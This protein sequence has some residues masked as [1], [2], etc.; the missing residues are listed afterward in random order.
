MNN[1][2]RLILALIAYLAIVYN[3][4]EIS[5]LIGV[6]STLFP[7]LT[8][9]MTIAVL[10]VIFIGSIKQFKLAAHIGLWLIVYIVS[11]WLFY[12]E[13]PFW[14]GMNIYQ[15]ATEMMLLAGAIAIAFR[16]EVKLQ[17]I[18]ELG[19]TITFPD[20]VRQVR[21]FSNSVEDIKVEFIRSRRYNHPLSLMVIEPAE[22]TLQEDL[23]RLIRENQKKISRKYL[24]SRLAEIIIH[25]ARRSDM[26]MAKDWDGRFVILCPENNAS[27]TNVLAQR[28]Q[29]AVKNSLGVSVQYGIAAFP[30][31]ALTLDELIRRAETNMSEAG[32]SAQILPGRA[33]EKSDLEILDSEI[34]ENPSQDSE[35]R[36]EDEKLPD[37]AL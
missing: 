4:N 16:L 2:N 5:R 15:T 1:R 37:E 3:L 24:A 25:Q 28:I 8:I 14:A 17:Q 7:V 10:A 29:A 32:P 6:N 36:P 22:Y 35:T 11:R 34:V 31:D 26:I 13:A 30:A 12:P 21:N 18:E 9:V 23:E 19:R 33:K 20:A 27:G